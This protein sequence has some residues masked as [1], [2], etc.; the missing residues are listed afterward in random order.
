MFVEF[1]TL[2]AAIGKNGV[3]DNLTAATT[4]TTIVRR[5]VLWD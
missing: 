2:L 1:R 5:Q 3:L 4:S